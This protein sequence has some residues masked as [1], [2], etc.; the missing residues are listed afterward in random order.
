MLCLQWKQIYMPSKIFC[1]KCSELESNPNH[2]NY[3]I[4]INFWKHACYI[5]HFLLQILLETSL[6][7]QH[8]MHHYQNTSLKLILD[9]VNA[10]FTVKTNLH[11]TQNI[12]H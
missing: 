4:T 5:N 3:T 6:D 7:C 8:S 9:E 12:L 1:I 10:V 2:L 11:A